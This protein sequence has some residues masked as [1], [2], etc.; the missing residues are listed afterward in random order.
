M[1]D[2][3]PRFADP[4][5]TYAALAAAHDGLD[6]GE[7]RRLDASLV[8][9]LANHIGNAAVLHDAIRLAR[10]AIRPTGGAA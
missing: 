8:L 5:A 4:D 2:T 10:Q 6:D 3:S 1:L 9:L 7:S